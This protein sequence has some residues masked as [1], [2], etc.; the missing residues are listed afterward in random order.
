MGKKLI[1]YLWFNDQAEEAVAHYRDIF[2]EVEQTRVLRYTKTVA[3]QAGK[4]EGSVMSVDFTLFG[5]R[6]SALNGGPMFQFTEA[7]S[8][9]VECEDQAEIDRYWDAIVAG[10]GQA[11]PCGWIKDKFGFSWQIVPRGLEDLFEGENADEVMK[12]MLAMPGKLDKK[13]LWDAAGAPQ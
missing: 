9:L 7:T 10:G 3:E 6:M 12:V 1:T 8:I 11:G 2:G 5:D 13:A 4:P